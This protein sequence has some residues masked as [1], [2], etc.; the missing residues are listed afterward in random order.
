VI[1]Y[2]KFT[3]EIGRFA[4]VMQGLIGR[5]GALLSRVAMVGT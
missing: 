1:F 4:G 3:V 5:S 2:N